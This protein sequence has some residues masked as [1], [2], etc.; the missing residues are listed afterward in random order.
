MEQY[1]RRVTLRF[2]RISEAVER[3]GMENTIVNIVI[4]LSSPLQ[5][6]GMESAVRIGRGITEGRPRSIIVR[7]TTDLRRDATYKARVNLKARNAASVSGTV[8]SSTMT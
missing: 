3:Y 6:R 7:F 1:S 2:Q 4:Q 8:F 5:T